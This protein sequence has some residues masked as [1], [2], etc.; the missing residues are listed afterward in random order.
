MS[1]KPARSGKQA[2][3]SAE[4]RKREGEKGVC[5]IEGGDTVRGITHAQC[6]KAAN[7]RDYCFREGESMGAEGSA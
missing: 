4:A 7:G 2:A 3:V 5:F 1:R 6:V